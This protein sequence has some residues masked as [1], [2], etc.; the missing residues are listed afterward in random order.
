VDAFVWKDDAQ[1]S[2]VLE[3][4]RSDANEIAVRSIW[5]DYLSCENGVMW[6]TDV[7]AAGLVGALAA[8]VGGAD[9]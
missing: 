8:I 6:L 2:V 5:P 7:D 4:E 3:I 1:V 9:E